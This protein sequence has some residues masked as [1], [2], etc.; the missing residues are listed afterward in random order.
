MLTNKID[1]GPILLFHANLFN[2]QACFEHS[3]LLTVND[4]ETVPDKL[5]TDTLSSRMEE[6]I[7]THPV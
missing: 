7:S 1:Q 4:E 2:G 6:A 5:M 3:I